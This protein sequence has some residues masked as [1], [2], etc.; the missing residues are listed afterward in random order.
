MKSSTQKK[1]SLYA[2]LI[3]FM[4]I[5]IS[6]SQNVLDVAD[7]YKIVFWFNEANSRLLLD[8]GAETLT[9]YVN[10]H[11]VATSAVDDIFWTS[12]PACDDSL[13]IF[14]QVDLFPRNRTIIYSI[15]DQTGFEYLNGSSMLST[16]FCNTIEIGPITKFK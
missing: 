6:C 7:R 1:S 10:G 2:S 9:F 4:F 16:N 3:L 5:C 14:A 8:D 11:A 15:K 13:S 12:A